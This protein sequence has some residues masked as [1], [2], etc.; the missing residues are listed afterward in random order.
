MVVD[1]WRPHSGACL[2]GQCMRPTGR[3]LT[4]FRDSEHLRIE[5]KESATWSDAERRLFVRDLPQWGSEPG[6]AGHT[7]G[8][9]VGR[10]TPPFPYCIWNIRNLRWT[11]CGKLP[12]IGRVAKQ[13]STRDRARHSNTM[14]SPRH[15]GYLFD[16]ATLRA[17][18]AYLRS[19]ADAQVLPT[20]P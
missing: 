12:I 17:S 4:N 5:W 11:T 1:G 16:L 14:H 2:V 20:H 9:P 19:P 8:T 13:P 15:N 6:S 18:E 10:P 3:G 7:A